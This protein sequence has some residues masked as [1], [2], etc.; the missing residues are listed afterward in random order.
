MPA[1]CGLCLLGYDFGD[2][3]EVEDR[4]REDDI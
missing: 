3:M 4:D 2:I 1:E